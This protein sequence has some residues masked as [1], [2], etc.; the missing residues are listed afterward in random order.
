VRGEVRDVEPA[1]PSEF[2]NAGEAGV[3]AM[4]E[5]TAQL[6]GTVMLTVV[7]GIGLH[8]APEQAARVAEAFDAL[9]GAGTW[10]RTSQM[11][12]LGW[13]GVDDFVGLVQATY[14]VL[15]EPGYVEFWRKVGRRFFDS[16][17]ATVIKG[18]LAAF[19]LR[20]PAL[21]R[22]LGVMWGIGARHAGKITYEPGAAEGQ[23][24]ML[25]EAP[26]PLLQPFFLLGFT[27]GLHCIFDLTETPGT[28]TWSAVRPGCV[29]LDARWGKAAEQEAAK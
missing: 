13:V 28:L 14:Q 15:G 12:R 25:F 3:A 18:F 9:R 27:E 10:Q 1:H 8:L 6:Q 29:A 2:S 24:R 22:A 26:E 16:A 4:S 20:P 19:G 23:G 11:C 5:Q 21:M 7:E 17:F